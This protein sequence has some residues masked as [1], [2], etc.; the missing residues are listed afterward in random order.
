MKKKIVCFS[1][2]TLFIV[3][4][5]AILVVFF[6]FPSEN[7]LMELEQT[8]VSNSDGTLTINLKTYEENDITFVSFYVTDGGNNIIYENTDGWRVWDFHSVTFDENDNIVVSTGDMGEE[9]YTHN[10]S[11]LWYK[12]D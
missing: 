1:I 3:L 7:S 6:S 10:S 2:L 8:R 12:T 11:G 9:I 4:V 5:M